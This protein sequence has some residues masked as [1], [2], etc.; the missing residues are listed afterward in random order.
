MRKYIIYCLIILV[1]IYSPIQAALTIDP[2]TT[3][4]WTA[5]AMNTVAE[6]ATVTCSSN[7]LTMLFIQAFLDST[8]A[9][10][11]TEFI[12]HL[13]S[14]D[15]GDED[16]HFFSKF[17]GLVGTA[18]SEAITNDP[19]TGSTSIHV[20]DTGGEYET[21]PLAHW[22]ALE[23]TTLADS[24]L[25]F[26]TAYSANAS[27]T[28]LDGVTNNHTSATTTLYDIA[29]TQTIILPLGTNRARVIV[30][31]THDD[32]GSSLNY[33]VSEVETTGL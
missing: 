30:N 32:N 21:T 27:I 22:I 20:A 33:K 12:I 24:E 6:S 26:Q 16:W 11:G 8:T 10:T 4:D 15:T 3:T 19:P 31:N 14:T 13:S 18:N 28:I 2:Q 1:L 25:V 17:T 23:N 7:Y 9:H 29:L 5:V